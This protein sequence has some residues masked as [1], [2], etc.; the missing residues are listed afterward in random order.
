MIVLY[1]CFQSHGFKRKTGPPSAAGFSAGHA[2]A[3]RDPAAE[4]TPMQD[5]WKARRSAKRVFDNLHRIR[6]I[7]LD[8]SKSVVPVLLD[9]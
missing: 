1:K 3:P 7:G 4:G 5:P 2:A 6:L 8:L 9:E